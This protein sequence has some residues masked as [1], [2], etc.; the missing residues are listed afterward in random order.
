MAGAA[1]TIFAVASG[2]GRA[3]VTVVRLSGPATGALLGRICRRRPHPRVASLRTLRAADGEVLDRALAKDPRDR[4]QSA[5][6]LAHEVA[7]AVTA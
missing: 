3:A 4:Q 6:E 1:E 2:A 5:A 7:V